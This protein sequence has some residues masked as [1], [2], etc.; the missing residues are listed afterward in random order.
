MRT[1]LTIAILLMVFA[2]SGCGPRSGASGEATPP[3]IIKLVG[4]DSMVNITQAWSEAYATADRGKQVDVSGGGSGI[5]MAALING[6][7]DVATLIREPEPDEREKFKARWGHELR[8]V[9]VGYDSLAVI[10]HR[11]NP[12]NGISIEKLAEVFGENGGIDRWEQLGVVGLG[13]IV[14]LGTQSYMQQE[15]FRR[16][17]FGAGLDGRVRREFKLGKRD[18]GGSHE[19]S[20]ACS[21]NRAAIGA[22]PFGYTRNKVKVLALASKKGDQFVECKAA[23][24][25][26]G[27]YPL[28]TCFYLCTNGTPDSQGEVFVSFA[29]SKSGQE[30]LK[31]QGHLPIAPADGAR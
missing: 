7:A 11:E 21:V 9:L 19:L 2:L 13:D 22:V 16:L 23:S 5:G 14:R 30:V 4:A 26:D 29:L 17:V 8:P 3:R 20:E 12:L 24:V 18:Y 31:D 15:K 27:S 6:S 1:S 10:V 25:Q 28:V